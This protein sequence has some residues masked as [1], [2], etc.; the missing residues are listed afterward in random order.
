[1][2]GL[3]VGSEGTLAVFGDIT[4][5]LIQRPESVTTL[6]A[7]FPD[8]RAASACVSAMTSTGVTARC[9]EFFDAST[10]DAMR[11][12][13]NPLDPRAGSLLLI[14]V[15]GSSSECDAA[16]E[17]V[18]GACESARALELL[19]AQDPAQRERLWAARREMSRAVRRLSRHKLSE[20]VVVPRQSAR[21]SATWW[22][23]AGP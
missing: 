12:A 8:V 10:L 23:S 15:D 5:K 11:A 2:T 1:V 21:C 20:D 18:G 19:V 14:E 6:L 22:R 3:L 17:R 13:G 4:L 9:I 7:L 16:A